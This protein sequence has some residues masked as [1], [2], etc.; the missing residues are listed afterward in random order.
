MKVPVWSNDIFW[1]SHFKLHNAHFCPQAN[2]WY[3][4]Q[5]LKYVHYNDINYST[6][7]LHFSICSSIQLVLVQAAD[8]M[9]LNNRKYGL[10]D[11]LYRFCSHNF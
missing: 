3:W 2:S 5:T 11:V 10:V 6:L 8:M 4:S 7:K 1:L 9:S